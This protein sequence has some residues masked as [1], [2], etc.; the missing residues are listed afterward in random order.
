MS[1]RYICQS[2]IFKY[3]NDELNIKQ[4]LLCDVIDKVR[5]GN[6]VESR[7]SEVKR[8]RRKGYR[9]LENKEDVFFEECFVRKD[10][11]L[12]LQKVLD[13]VKREEL[14]FPGAEGYKDDNYKS[15]SLRML[16]FGLENCELPSSE[17]NIVNEDQTQLTVEEEIPKDVNNLTVMEN[18]TVIVNEVQST[19]DFTLIKNIKEN[20]TYIFACFVGM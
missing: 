8:G 20:W 10:E 16:K 3:I 6:M 5:P 12:G 11:E 1:K 7:V 18:G 19:F 17:K 2:D 9:G 13:F 15:Y 4:S 14:V